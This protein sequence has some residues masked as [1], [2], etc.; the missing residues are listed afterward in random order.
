MLKK[1]LLDVVARM[2]AKVFLGDEGCRNEDWLRLTK[3]LTVDLFHAAVK[4]AGIP[5]GIRHI[6]HWF[7]PE[8]KALREDMRIGREIINKMLSKRHEEK[9]RLRAEG[10]EP[11]FNDALEW[12]EIQAHAN[13]VKLDYGVAQLFLALAAIR[14]W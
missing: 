10:I 3:E 5:P 11:E 1:T 13:G 14:R 2:S 7:L 4:L 8:C 12:Y 6:V 9:K